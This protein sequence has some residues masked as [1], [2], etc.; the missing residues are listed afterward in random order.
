MER[1]RKAC[2]YVSPQNVSFPSVSGL[3][4]SVTKSRLIDSCR[5]CDT[6]QGLER[7]YILRD[8]SEIGCRNRMFWA[9]RGLGFS[10]PDGTPPPKNIMSIPLP[11]NGIVSLRAN[12][13]GK[14]VWMPWE[15]SPGNLKDHGKTK[16][17]QRW[18]TQVII[19]PLAITLDFL[20]YLQ[21]RGQYSD[22]NLP[23]PR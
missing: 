4:S 12:D 16:G 7:V 13:P 14:E 20:R 17:K 9:E 21:C 19:T 11:G 5:N 10:G 3:E 1:G 6:S 8:R 23:D 22:E 15:R 18:R 2:W